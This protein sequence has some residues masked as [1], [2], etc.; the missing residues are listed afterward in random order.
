MALLKQ[1]YQ[2]QGYQLSGRQLVETM[3]AAAM[4]TAQPVLDPRSAAST[5]SGGMTGKVPY[6]PRVQGAGVMQIAKAIKT[7]SIIT[8]AK[9]KAGVSL[10]E[11]GETT[12]FSL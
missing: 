12:T 6:S 4:N 10:G 7:P 8:D 9:G 2:K 1:A 11:V 5:A 3:K